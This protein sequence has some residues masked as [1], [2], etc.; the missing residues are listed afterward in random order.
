M[1]AMALSG[2][3]AGLTSSG[4]TDTIGRFKPAAWRLAPAVAWPR[5]A[6]KVISMLA[7]RSP[8][9]NSLPKIFSWVAGSTLG[10]GNRVT[11][12]LCLRLVKFI[13]Q[14]DTATSSSESNGIDPQIQSIQPVSRGP[15]A[16]RV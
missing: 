8:K 13:T 11:A 7:P 6:N 2:T 14:L 15:P 5:F 16:N 4:S 12:A 3:R 9:V 1:H 10:A